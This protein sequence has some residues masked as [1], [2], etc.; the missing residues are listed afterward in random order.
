MMGWRT[1]KSGRPYYEVSQGRHRPRLYVG[2]GSGASAVAELYEIERSLRLGQ[3]GNR[4]L[5]REATRFYRRW[6]GS[7]RPIVE[8]FLLVHDYRI[9]L[10][11]WRRRRSPWRADTPETTEIMGM[12]MLPELL[13]PAHAGSY[14]A[15][16]ELLLRAAKASA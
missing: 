7:I 5:W 9:D 15:K 14:S 11:R 4:R 6:W 12:A 13:K 10:G 1:A 16:V 3:H 2:M 8:S